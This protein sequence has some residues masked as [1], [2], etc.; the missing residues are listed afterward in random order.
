MV[1]WF[2]RGPRVSQPE[3]S[4][5]EPLMANAQPLV[6][7][8]PLLIKGIRVGIQQHPLYQVHHQNIQILFMPPFT[9]AGSESN[10]PYQEMHS[11]LTLQS[12]DLVV[13]VDRYLPKI[14]IGLK[15]A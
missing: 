8:S 13:P 9:W 2:L 7:R 5:C 12:P 14:R 6:V 1:R 11:D 15:F 3:E 10:H 4:S